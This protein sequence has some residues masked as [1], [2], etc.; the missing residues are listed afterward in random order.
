MTLILT[1]APHWHICQVP[2]KYVS[3]FPRFGHPRGFWGPLGEN[4]LCSG[5][6]QHRFGR[7]PLNLAHPGLQLVILG[8]KLQIWEG[9][10][11]RPKM[12][13]VHGIQ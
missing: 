10:V 2:E 7:A 6:Q 1:N 12:A 9:H 8:L 3:H 4:W 5:P 11:S 13:G